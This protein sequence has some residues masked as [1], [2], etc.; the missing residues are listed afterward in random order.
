MSTIRKLT[1]QEALASGS[2]QGEELRKMG[3]AVHALGLSSPSV[4]YLAMAFKTHC[5]MLEHNATCTSTNLWY[6]QALL[7]A[8][9]LHRLF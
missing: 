2:E 9:S 4:P 1:E 6:S 7:M 3:V 8:M 5:T